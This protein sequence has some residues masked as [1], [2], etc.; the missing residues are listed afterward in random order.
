M[1]D[2]KCPIEYI[3]EDIREVV[4]LIYNNN[5]KPYNSCS[6]S[7]KDHKDESLWP[8][9]ASIEMLDSKLTRELLAILI[10]DKRFK[11]SISKERECV[12]YDNKLPEG[13]RFKIEFENICGDM[14][15]VLMRLMQSVIQGKK[16]EIGNRKEIDIVCDFI[17]DFDV[18]HGNEIKFSFNDEMTLKDHEN[19][20][21]YSI[22][23]K[24]KRKFESLGKSINHVIDGFIQDESKCKIYGSNFLSMISV[25]KKIRMDYYKIP[26]LNPGEKV[27]VF[28]LGSKRANKFTEG[29]NEKIKIAQEK[30]EQELRNE[31]STSESFS[32]DDLMGMIDLE[33]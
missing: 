10:K 33:K 7:Y 8:E 11:C 18:I 27:Q 22:E 6:G 16:A 28:Q 21:N 31:L 19:E 2:W 15:Q 12:L 14:Q 26:R 17:A 30:L 13:L 32:F 1:N 24:D 4:R 5:M 25:L 9:S 29:Y 20:D 23:I 3:D